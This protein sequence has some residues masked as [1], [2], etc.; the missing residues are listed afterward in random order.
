MNNI[1]KPVA[2]MTKKIREETQLV[3]WGRSSVVLCL[4]RRHKALGSIPGSAK[5]NTQFTKLRKK[6]RTSLL[7]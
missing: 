1:D 3:S 4:P 7:T 2:S 6:E 5:L